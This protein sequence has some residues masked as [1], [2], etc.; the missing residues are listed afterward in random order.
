VPRVQRVVDVSLVEGRVGRCRVRPE[1][2]VFWVCG[3]GI[4]ASVGSTVLHLPHA[5]LRNDS[6]STRFAAPR[7][8]LLVSFVHRCDSRVTSRRHRLDC[9]WHGG[10][11][12]CEAADSVPRCHN[13][14]DTRPSARL[15]PPPTTD[16]LP[17]VDTFEISEDALQH[18]APLHFYL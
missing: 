5:L 10:W 7:S 3:R 17:V 8:V 11:S 14:Q 1:R 6:T 13:R 12:G 2:H 4:D 9:H 16:L 15:P 18:P